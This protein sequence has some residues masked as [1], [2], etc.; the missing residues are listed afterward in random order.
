LPSYVDT[1]AYEVTK[2]NLKFFRDLSKP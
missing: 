2:E 1:G